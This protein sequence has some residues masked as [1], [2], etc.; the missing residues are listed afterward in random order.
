MGSVWRAQHLDLDAPVA[1]KLLDPSIAM[2]AEG[3]TRFH[4]EAQ[5]AA[6]LRS[7]HVVQIFDRGLDEATHQPYI[8]MELMEGESLAARVAR[9]GLLSPEQTA[10]IVTHIARALSRA[11]D[12][13]IVHRDLKPDNV[14]LVL[15]EDEEVAKVLDFGIAKSDRHRLDTDS[16]TRT[17]AVMGTPYYMSPEQISGSKGVDFRTDLWALGVIACECLT[18]RRPFDAETIGG[19]AL[20]ICAEA[21]PVPS[22]LGPVSPAF[23]AWF[24][25]ATARD[26]TARFSSARDAADE[27]RRACGVE[28]AVR[29]VGAEPIRTPGQVHTASMGG[30]ARS[31]A[32]AVTS[33][34]TVAPFPVWALVGGLL[35]FGAV[36]A[37]A[38]WF[39]LGRSADVAPDAPSAA[40]PQPTEAPSAAKLDAPEAATKTAAPDV[41][42]TLT[43]P[44]APPS[45]TAAATPSATA[46][47]DAGSSPGSARTARTGV[48]QKRPAASVT[49]SAKSTSGSRSPSTIGTAI[50]QRR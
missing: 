48:I 3:I 9:L 30:L 14:F 36:A 24:A 41:L 25:R 32:D 15:N 46:A 4:R 38:A 19:L 22:R 8:V 49:P 44:A 26:P 13:G 33:G 34:P 18:G 2:N 35:S 23:D 27:L 11:H 47:P 50:D 45:A 42:P 37:G 21:P 43:P 10:R 1:V 31:S 16:H 29:P 12:A 40:T 28:G 5:A 6:A 20:K 39:F 17:G 7:P